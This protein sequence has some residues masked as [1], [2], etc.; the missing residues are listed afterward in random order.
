M[1]IRPDPR[2]W[3]WLG[4]LTVAVIGGFLRFW[5]L[6]R[7]PWIAFDETYYVK[8][9][10][11]LTRF[12]VEVFLKPSLGK[13]NEAQMLAA[14]KLL[15]TG[16]SDIFDPS[17]PDFVV[18]PPLGE[19]VIGAGPWLFGDGTSPFG[20]RF[21]VALLGSLSILMLG[22]IATR[23]FGSALL[24]T[25]A[26]LLLAVDGTHFTLSR[27]AVLD[28]MVMFWALAAFGC[29]LIDRDRARA[30]L[31]A[32]GPTR[33][34]PGRG[35]RW[36]RLAAGVC[37]GCCTATKWSGLYFTAVFCLATVLWDVAARRAA[38][39][40]HWL[41]VG[42]LRDGTAA[43]VQILPIAAL[44][45]LMTWTGWIRSTHGYG[46]AWAADHPG[47][48]WAGQAPD[49]FRSLAQ[50]HL[51]MYRAAISI[52]SEHAYMSNPW[53]W[54]VQGRPTS[55]AYLEWTAGNHPCP[56]D[57]CVRAVTSLGNPVIWWVGTVAIA[58]VLVAWL[59]GR[60][61]RAGAVL[62]GIA[63]GYLPWFAYQERTVFTFYTVAF[64]PYVVL[65]ITY[66]LGLLLG[67][68]DAAPGR[69]RRGGLAA[70]SIVVAAVVTFAFF[71]PVWSA[72]RISHAAWLLRMWLPSWI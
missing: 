54:L 7:P 69:R 27:I 51:E 9:G 53:S 10:L 37:L 20:W 60:D 3:G 28:I 36:W 72:Q 4:P 6:D 14:N 34:G 5:H 59:L 2:L 39:A 22:R 25:T 67:P 40:R 47:T 52:T 61:G 62:A 33:F 31:L 8:E 18:D 44:T 12:G 65:A 19:W 63:A 46:R 42:L 21:G 57:R 32:R 48:G 43:A 29:L 68:P 64:V 35:L 11:S 55:I 41:G 24:G 1:T 58:V 50:L 38:G 56:H 13:D 71:Y 16:S 66:A 15:E 26:A 23:L 30:R 45:Y 49:W 70:G 17:R